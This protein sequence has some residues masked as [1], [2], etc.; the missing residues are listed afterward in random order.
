MPR[1][2]RKLRDLADARRFEDAGRLQD[3]IAAL[4]RVCRELDRLA[5]MRRA[6][7]CL[8]VPALEPGFAR[9]YFVT[10]GRIASVRTLPPGDGAHLEIEAGL[11]ACRHVPVTVTLT[12]LEELMVIESFLRK[13]PPELVI[14]PLDKERILAARRVANPRVVETRHVP[15]TVTST[16]LF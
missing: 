7:C 10:G 11:A 13:P 3:R 4:E 15:V 14:C 9:A 12:C 8:V 2:R 6:R 1:L 5:R 16:C